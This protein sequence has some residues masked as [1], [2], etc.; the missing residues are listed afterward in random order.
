M[1]EIA[2]LPEETGAEVQKLAPDNGFFVDALVQAVRQQGRAS[3]I[4]KCGMMQ[5]L[6]MSQL[7]G[8]QTVRD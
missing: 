4:A 6:D 8:L 1:A 3:I 5:V 2:D 7:I